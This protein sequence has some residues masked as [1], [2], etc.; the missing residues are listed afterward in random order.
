MGGGYV[1][2][3]SWEALGRFLSNPLAIEA[4]A[5]I[6]L[7]VGILLVF[8]RIRRVAEELERRRALGDYVRGLD[9]FL[10]GDFRDAIQTL[11][12]V[13]ERDPENVEARIALGD[14][15]REL[16]DAAEAK[17]HHHHVHKVF[18][19]ELAR[20][21]LSLGQDE[22]ALQNYDRAVKAFERCLELAPQESDAVAG[23]AQAYAEG[24]NPLEAAGFLRQL[25]PEGP[26]QELGVAERRAAARRFAEAGAAALAD[27]DA[28]HAIRLYTEALAFQPRDVRARTGLVRAAHALG[29]PDRA[30]AL[31]RKHVD[32][33][34][35]LAQAED[36]LFE[37]VAA[38]PAEAGVTPEP[39]AAAAEAEAGTSFLPAKIEEVGG[40]VA[41]VEAKTARYEC[42]HC[43]ALQ[44]DYAEQCPA[45]GAVGTLA[46]LTELASLYT[47]PVADFREAV[48]AVEE[49]AAFVQGLAYRAS[50]GDED[51]LRRLIELGPQ[52]LYD[53][54]PAL[55]SIEAR[56]YLGH[57]LAAIAAAGGGGRAARIVR[58]CHAARTQDTA[59][60]RAHDEFAAAFYLTL[61]E[62][63]Q[64]TCLTSL[65][66]ARDAALAVSMADPRLPDEVRDAAARWL[67]EN[68]LVPVIEAVAASGDFG[69]VER[70]ARLVAEW[71]DAAV[72]ALEKRY[73]QATLLGRLFRGRKGVRRRACADVLART[74][75]AS[76]AAALG[77][78]AAKEKDPELRAHY[79]ACR[80]RAEQGGCA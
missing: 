52:V 42:Q 67:D 72:E 18:G 78:A 1:A 65:G 46:A 10:R 63:D 60:A 41:A 22:L 51:A 35:E 16:G 58:E 20:N 73:F 45:C 29:D 25:Y 80:E 38:R 76:A 53:I 15:Y 33:L 66:A 77:K 19:H 27:G 74:G 44:R 64:E 24:G 47:M 62:G 12:R 71:G 26:T 57:R 68:A 31:V 43:G 21:F 69:G 54:F 75:L 37:P 28:E 2:E 9:E 5:A 39:G 36:V 11:E 79:V 3:L 32:A 56:G 23:L 13:L 61:P 4:I 49:N 8:R 17:K 34:R 40:V 50:T 59:T 48:D 55:R 30:R 70:A 14:C 7:F 6:L